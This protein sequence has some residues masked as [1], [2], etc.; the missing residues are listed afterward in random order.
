MKSRATLV[1]L[2]ALA[3]STLVTGCGSVDDRPPTFTYVYEA[4]IANNCAT[5]GCHNSFRQTAGLQFN[6]KAGAYVGLTGTACNDEDE[7]EANSFVVAGR[8]DASQ[9]IHMLRG[10]LVGRRM[11]PDRGIS[12]VDIALVEEWILEGA[13]CD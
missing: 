9:V 13:L 1:A 3:L 8:P 12:S 10:D 6:T 7:Y 4:V 11:P 2:A 5:I